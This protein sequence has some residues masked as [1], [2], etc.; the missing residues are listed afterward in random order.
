MNAFGSSL[1][2]AWACWNGGDFRRLAESALT[3]PVTIVALGVLLLNDLLLKALWPGS[4]FTG[5]LSDLAWLVFALPLLAWGVALWVWGRAVA[6]ASVLRWRWGLLV[7]GITALGSVACVSDPHEVGVVRLGIADD[8]SIVALTHEGDYSRRGYGGAGYYGSVDGGLTW[9]SLGDFTISSKS[10]SELAEWH[11]WRDVSEDTP[12]GTYTLNGPDVILVDLDGRRQVAYSTAYLLEDGNA[13][14][15]RMATTRHGD[16][17]I[18]VSE[19]KGLIY[20]E[21][22]GNLVLA[23]EIQGV[24][25]GTPGGEWA[26]VAA[27]RFQPADFRFTT[28]T[29]ML[30]TH[31]GFWITALTLA[32][33]MTAAGLFASY[34]RIV[35]LLW[36]VP[37]SLALCMAIA[38]VLTV[39]GAVSAAA[40]VL[41]CVAGPY[42]RHCGIGR[43]RPNRW[44][45]LGAR[46]PHNHFGSGFRAVFG[47]T[48]LEFWSDSRHCSPDS[49]R[50]A[51]SGLDLVRD[52]GVGSGAGLPVAVDGRT[53]GLAS[54]LLV[55]RGNDRPHSPDVHALAAPGDWPRARQTR[56]AS[57]VCCGRDSAC[58]L[59][60]TRPESAES[61]VGGVCA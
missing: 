56:G 22:S 26:E 19:P 27:G 60:E 36:L 50:C 29:L 5:K 33:S 8:G 51:H 55:R 54:G 23:M 45:R 34:T 47:R 7:V 48:A 35:R 13:W 44:S 57:S 15:L 58:R 2:S 43:N 9:N 4:W 25:V 3:H 12:R 53:D 1:T 49:R 59:R 11:D 18:L 30:L 14:I 31:A 20:D 39:I 38:A 37:S 41:G 46:L 32:F 40:L 52:N 42:S 10:H 24:V 6:N 21:T 17:R 61:Q 16:G 28:K